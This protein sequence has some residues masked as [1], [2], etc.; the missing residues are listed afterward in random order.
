MQSIIA[1]RG[2]YD[3]RSVA[4]SVH[5]PANGPPVSGKGPCDSTVNV[6][7]LVKLG[8][9]DAENTDA[10]FVR[11]TGLLHGAFKFEVPDQAI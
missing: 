8:N 10:P 5:W 9:Y 6:S 2:V 1:C 3:E 11:C 7:V 4:Y